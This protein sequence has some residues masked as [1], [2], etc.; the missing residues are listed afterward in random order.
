MKENLLFYFGFLHM[1]EWKKTKEDKNAL[2]LQIIW[3]IVKWTT[4]HHESYQ[5][6]NLPPSSLI[7][8]TFTVFVL[9]Q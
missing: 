9:S 7:Q 2:Q 5:P 6:A 4:N 8:I 1:W 3:G